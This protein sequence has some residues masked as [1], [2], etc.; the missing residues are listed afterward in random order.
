ML[1][2]QQQSDLTNYHDENLITDLNDKNNE[3]KLNQTQLSMNNLL[4]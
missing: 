4:T 2:N 1:D 3:N